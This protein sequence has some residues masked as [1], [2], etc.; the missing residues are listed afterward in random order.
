MADSIEVTG[1]EL[2][3]RAFEAAIR[4][5]E[6][7]ID[8]LEDHV[9]RS[10]KA[11]QRAESS[12]VK[13]G[14]AILGAAAAFGA[15]RVAQDVARFI[16][17]TNVEFEK[18]E[19]RLITIEG[20]AE[21]AAEAFNLITTFARET[22]F[23]VQNLV[24]AFTMLRAAGIQPTAEMMRDLGNFSAAM[25]RDI[26]DAVS[27]ILRAA[28]GGTERLRESF[29]IPIEK[30]GD[31]LRITWK[32]VTSEVAADTE[33]LLGFFQ[34][35]SREDFG[36]GMAR[37]MDT[38][39]G[40]ITN[41]K[42]TLDLLARDVG[43]GGLNAEIA[44]LARSLDEVIGASGE[45]ATVLGT[46]LAAA[47]REAGELGK[48]WL[49]IL[50]QIG[51][52]SAVV[53]GTKMSLG[54]VDDIDVLIQRY[55]EFMDLMPSV[56]RSLEENDRILKAAGLTD[57]D[58]GQILRFIEDRVKQ[59]REQAASAGAAPATP[60]PTAASGSTDVAKDFDRLTQALERQR[61]ELEGG[62]RAA[63]AY[64]LSL[65]KLTPTQ[66]E[67]VLATWDEV[68]ALEA[69]S[70]AQKEAER[71]ALA[72]ERAVASTLEGLKAQNIELGQG[73]EAL[74]RWSLATK[75]ATD[76]QIDA[77]VV[78]LRANEAFEAQNRQLEQA[79][80]E[81]QAQL[82]AEA[83]W[84]K[85]VGDRL[86]GDIV[87]P[88]FDVIDGTKSAKEAF[89]DMVD[90]FIRD[91]LRLT[92]QKSITDPLAGFLAGALGAAASSAGGGG[93]GAGTPITFDQLGTSA[94]AI[95][96]GPSTV[97]HQNVTLALAAYDGRDA[98]RFIQEQRGEIVEVIGEA[99]RGSDAARSYMLGG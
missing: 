97:I 66:R 58:V 83:Q 6:R 9:D 61:R 57:R 88:L 15:F 62:E 90:S 36:D 53:A 23:E 93:S 47:L 4:R 12:F 54:N 42:D 94:Q 52:E 75:G 86:A 95:G 14:G 50:N 5:A 74:L 31:Q 56:N 63:F 67:Q 85:T 71:Q 35:L 3:T 49:L 38:M 68:Q 81:A 80:R 48:E 29:F 82:E 22:P 69:Q 32:G 91:L 96:G 21:K 41:L 16:F 79:A 60:G 70:A 84:L 27:A 64:E 13:W 17:D 8:D 44:A 18:L 73:E 46:S 55:V 65:A 2:D 33:S 24:E 89:S 39:G 37:Q 92:V 10:G 87:D 51:G 72:N 77:A 59:L 20:S 1:L 26:T 28:Q 78:L 19:G 98:R 25:G 45:L 99:M 76:E 30:D 34:R 11:A 43:V 7:R 40:A